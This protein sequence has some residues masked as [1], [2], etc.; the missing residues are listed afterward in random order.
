MAAVALALSVVS[1][2]LA[3]AAC[4]LAGYSL[5]AGYREDRRR[6]EALADRAEELEDRL[7]SLAVACQR[8]GERV[9]ALAGELE[10]GWKAVL[11][12]LRHLDE[13]T[14]ALERKTEV[15]PEGGVVDA[16]EG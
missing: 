8:L 7:G 3:L 6:L 10:A 16:A 15:L 4:A 2:A 12:D 13:R 1:L 5:L 9:E 14:D 11:E